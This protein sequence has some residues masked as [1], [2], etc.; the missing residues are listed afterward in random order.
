M[1]RDFQKQAKASKLKEARDP[2]V[3]PIDLRYAD[4]LR[5]HMNDPSVTVDLSLYAR[6]MHFTKA[7]AHWEVYKKVADLPGD[8]VECGVYKGESLLNW[9]RFME[10]LNPG[11]RSKRVIGFDHF[12]GL[13]NLTDNDIS[14]GRADS[15]EGGWNP[16]GFKDTLLELIDLF[17]QDSFVPHA[18]RIEII[19]GDIRETAK[20]RTE[21]EL[22]LRIA[23]LHLDC[24]LYEP[25]L[26]A[27]QAFYP[28]VVTGGIVLLDEY[29]MAAWPGESRAL[30][31]YFDG[32][33]PRL[34]KLPWQSSPGGWFVKTER[35]PVPPAK[36]E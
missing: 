25:T 23:L 7:L 16:D 15:R 28:R 27:L 32:M 13:K 20:A 22:G 19:D 33:P 8:V 14:D 34:E 2:R 11:D 17:H 26:A 29:G 30:E 1:T 5:R 36:G 6:R 18:P 12:E 3:A 35:S 10:A 24:D 9:A 31:D 21:Q 4:V